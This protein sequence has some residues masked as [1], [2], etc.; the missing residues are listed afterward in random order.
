MAIAGLGGVGKTQV[1]LEFAYAVKKTQLE[2]S[3]FWMPALSMESFEQ[4]CAQIARILGISQAAEDKEDVKE[5]VRRYLSSERAGQW[6]LIV[7]NADDMEIVTGSKQVRGIA[8]YLPHSNE[9]L[10]LFTTRTQEAAVALARS[11]V[12]KLEAMSRQEAVDLLKASLIRKDLLNS[13][14]NT[15]DLLDELTYLPLAIAQA[16][17]YLNTN[18][19]SVSEYLRLLRNTEQDMV[20]LLSREF[21]DNTRYRGSK[22]AVATTWLVSFN[23]IL[24]HD[25]AAADL[26]SFMSCIAPNAIPR[27]ILPG[28]ELE[29]QMVHAIGTLCA[30]ALVVRRADKETYDLHRLVH[31]ATRVWLGRS[32]LACREDGEGY[33]TCCNGIPIG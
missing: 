14:S 5:L 10:V 12:I 6:L 3:V 18:E 11:H 22:N 9:G 16:A 25:L 8:D 31:V 28:V 33:S 29:E 15:T 23:Q 20:S 7:D 24:K 17:A 19:E 2:Y 30:Y 13:D 4:A 26:L 32:G 21:Y 1:A 27:S